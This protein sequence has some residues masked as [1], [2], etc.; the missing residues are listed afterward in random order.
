VPRAAGARRK[1]ARRWDFKRCILGE[2]AVDLRGQEVERR[3]VMRSV[4]ISNK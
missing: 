1:R 2:M 3:R 4:D